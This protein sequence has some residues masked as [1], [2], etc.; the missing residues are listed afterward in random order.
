[1]SAFICSDRHIATIAMAYA[2]HVR[3]T[4]AFASNLANTLKRENIRSVNYRYNQRHHFKP[5]DL[6]DALPVGAGDGHY[7][8]VDLLQLAECLDYQSCERDD[9]EKSVAYRELQRI[10]A[11]F[12]ELAA[13]QPWNKSNVWSI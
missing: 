7:R 5:C 12:K 1:M 4:E 11:Q 10:I 2:F 9:Y 13:R 8:A 3:E 6:S